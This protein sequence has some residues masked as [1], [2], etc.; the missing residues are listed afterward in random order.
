MIRKALRRHAAYLALA[1]SLSALQLP[2]LAQD[3]VGPPSGTMAATPAPP[4]LHDALEKDAP[5]FK[6]ND[7]T[8]NLWQS[9]ILLGMRAPQTLQIKSQDEL[10][11]LRGDD[12]MPIAR[13][14]GAYDLMAKEEKDTTPTLSQDATKKLDDYIVNYSRSLLYNDEVTGKLKEPTTEELKTYYE[15]NKESK[16]KQNEELR[17]RQI[18]VST[19]VPYTVK[20]GDTLES[21]AKEVGS[22]AALAPK[23]L[24]DTT[25]RERALELEPAEN[26]EVA[27]EDNTPEKKKE[28]EEK[29]AELEKKA[30][31]PPRALVDGEKLLVPVKGD[32]ETKAQEK[33]NA[34]Y[35][36]LEG[37]EDFVAVAKDVSENA[38]PGEVLVIRPD[39]NDRPPMKELLDAFKGLEN[40]KYSPVIQ[41]KHGFHIV[42][43]DAYTPKGYTPFETVQGNL[44][45]LYKESK[46]QSLSEEFLK[47]LAN[48]PANMKFNAENLAKDA[49]AMKPDDVIFKVGDKEFTRGQIASNVPGLLD[50][51]AKRNEAT[52]RGEVWKIDP[53]QMALIDQVRISRGYDK[54]PKVEF[55]REAASDTLRAF[56]ILKANGDNAVKGIT[57][58]ELK[59]QYETMKARFVVPATFDVD[60][61]TVKAA[62]VGDLEAAVK[63]AQADLE[64]KLEGV[65]SEEEFKK[66]ADE[67]NEKDPNVAAGGKRGKVSAT[68]LMKDELDALNAAEIPGKTA[69]VINGG[70][71]VAFWLNGKEAEK[72]MPFDDV[73]ARLKAQLGRTRQTTANQ[74]T[75]KKYSEM[76]QVEILAK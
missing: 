9:E 71:V 17:M 28:A 22:D 8:Y 46:Q 52:V 53:V 65:N 41:T 31:L 33:A 32:A 54:Q 68:G 19:Y 4:V 15:E 66:L 63:Q 40:G 36:R 48:D 24:S 42:Y 13:S 26:P 76:S 2:A 38:A 67:V 47:G 10:A 21:I 57:D 51:A 64:K 62:S 34:A 72:T 56:E 30:P 16:F 5:L 59:Q 61:I 1:G 3:P 43:R 70:S 75:L 55:A 29:K 39:S 14:Y 18:F 37:G 58:E 60:Q 23:I 12:L 73:K 11:K 7:K 20:A 6:V 27:P 49:G 50:D 25:K 44:G 74:D 45:S 69:V 35:K